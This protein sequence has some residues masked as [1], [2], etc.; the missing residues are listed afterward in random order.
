MP[1][2]RASCVAVLLALAAFRACAG[3]DVPLELDAG[4]RWIY[5]QSIERE[6]SGPRGAHPEFQPAY[7]DESGDW[8]IVG[9]P[10]GARHAP[11]LEMQRVLGVVDGHGCMVDVDGA[12]SLQ[13]SPCTDTLNPGDHWSMD[14]PRR[15][16]RRELK[17]IG[18]ESVQVPAG[19]FD[20]IRLEAFDYPAQ[21]AA[22]TS[23]Q[24]AIRHVVLW[25][26]PEARTVARA[27]RDVLAADGTVVSHQVDVLESF[28]HRGRRTPAGS[29]AKEGASTAY[30]ARPIIIY[31][32]SD[33]EPHYPAAAARAGAIGTTVLRFTVGVDARLID[34]QVVGASGSTR[35][36][37]LLDG[38]ARNSFASCHFA[39]ARDSSGKPIQKSG[40]LDYTWKLN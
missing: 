22:D 7:R 26:A 32:A 38:A 37:R 5:V 2:V 27:E 35:E 31:A 30:A 40:S 3:S 6:G 10:V 17:V 23:A 14:Y 24:P 33:C 29:D 15:S 13:N 11:D 18:R 8:A 39:S 25:F 9:N 12:A 34:L 28:V 1:V 4:D 16:M 19:R 36:H 21:P 20:A